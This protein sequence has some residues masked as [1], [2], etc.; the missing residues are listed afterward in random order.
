MEPYGFTRSDIDDVAALVADPVS[1]KRFYAGTTVA[2]FTA[3][4][5]VIAPSPEP[6]APV[7]VA[8]PGKYVC[9]GKEVMV[10]I[11]PVPQNL[12]QNDGSVLLDA[13]RLGFPFELRP[14]REGDWMCPLGLG[15]KKRKLSDI[16]VSLKVA[17]LEKD[18]V[19]L[20]SY[21][22]Q[23][24]RVAAIAGF[25]RIDDSLKATSA[26]NTVIRIK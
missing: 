4:K 12:V 6:W 1:G 10:S 20:V 17:A 15:G 16:F 11:E 18:A 14:W 26:T 21:P 22:G 19:V 5:L 23:E 3:T 25:G 2:Y 9:G 8:G 13:D 24:G 7:Q